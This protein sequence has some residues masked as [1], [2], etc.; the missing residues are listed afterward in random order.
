MKEYAIRLA[1][2]SGGKAGKGHNK[3][4]TVQ[5]FRGSCIVKSFRFN[6]N[7]RESLKAAMT[8]AA[9]Y[10]S[11]MQKAE[12]DLSKIAKLVSAVCVDCDGYGHFNDQDEP[13][14]DRRCRKCLGCQGTGK[15]PCAS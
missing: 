9:T 1:R 4:S 2:P 13:T 15:I 6:M 11:K 14:I 3:T 12:A 8:N 7:D 10:V 5:V